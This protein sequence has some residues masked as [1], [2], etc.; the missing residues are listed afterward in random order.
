M[1]ASATV[2][3]VQELFDH[4]TDLLH[5]FR[6]FRLPEEEDYLKTCNDEQRVQDFCSVLSASPHLLQYVRRLRIRLAVS[7]VEKLS[8][9]QFA[10]LREI[11]F[12]GVYDGPIPKEVVPMAARL[13]GLPL[14]VY[15]RKP[16][17][18][19]VGLHTQ[20]FRWLLH[21]QSPVDCSHLVDVDIGHAFI[22][23]L[24]RHLSVARLTV[25]RLS[26]SLGAN[27]SQLLDLSDFPALTILH[28]T[29]VGHML[30]DV[31]ALFEPSLCGIEVLVLKIF[32]RQ[33]LLAEDLLCSF[34]TTIATKL[35]GLLRLE[36]NI[37]C[38]LLA[39]KRGRRRLRPSTL[40]FLAC[41]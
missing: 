38:S 35:P 30:E 39:T 3:Q 5:V 20:N 13:V 9:F 31:A 27:P 23:P 24:L 14:D 21:P 40:R 25:Q 26:F 34:D 33:G 32:R 8:Q 11:F 22:S 28:I 2:L 15:S 41:I 17:R 4:I 18:S 10:N 12:Y 16:R 1:S 36:I 6:N 37:H 29:T 19:P 7:T